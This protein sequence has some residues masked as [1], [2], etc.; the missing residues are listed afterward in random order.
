MKIFRF[1]FSLS[2]IF[3]EDLREGNKTRVET[4]CTFTVDIV[5][6]WVNCKCTQ[7]KMLLRC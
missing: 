4:L 3:A 1:A 6:E 5:R 7:R 2:T